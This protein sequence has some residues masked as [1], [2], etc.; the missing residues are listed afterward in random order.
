MSYRLAA[1]ALFASLPTLPAQA[2][3][4][5]F[6]TPSGDVECRLT[7]GSLD[8]S[9]FDLAVPLSGK[10]PRECG[11][12]WGHRYVLLSEGPVHLICGGPAGR[13]ARQD[14]APYGISANWGP[15]RCT[16]DPGGLMCHNADG[17]G[18]VLARDAVG[19]F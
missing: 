5:P 2:E 16:S 12:D 4:M 1:L 3:P 17:H 9:V 13:A 10:G 14:I 7:S 11:S 18:F 6:A 19:V 8:C 15:I